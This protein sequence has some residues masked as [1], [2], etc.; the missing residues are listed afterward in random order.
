MRTMY[1]AVTA[2]NIPRSAEMVAGY[3]DKIK[4]EPWTAADWALFPNAVKVTIVKKAS[5]NAGHV[6][7]VEP[8]DATPAQAPGWVRMRRAASADPSIYC[9]KSVWGT[10]Q[11][12]FKDQGVAQ[13]HYWIAWWNGDPTLPSLNGITAVAKQHSGDTAAGVDINSVADFWPGVDG[14]D[15]ATPEEIGKAVWD[16]VVQNKS[17][18]Q[19]IPARELVGWTL[20][21][22][23]R[24]ND[25]LGAVST[26]L[27][28]LA[29]K[30]AAQQGVPT[31]ELAD[32]LLTGLLPEVKA[33][34]ADVQ[35]LD[36][37]AVAAKVDALIAARYAS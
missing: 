31:A 16:S 37:D 33:E 5:T 32:A 27:A 19:N 22:V 21:G 3:I 24:A 14:D 34:L 35:H 26:K 28:D 36:E 10:V 29:L 6:L 23:D 7:D 13:P 4:L 9:N 2:R 17:N 18:G 1:D 12:A 20:R 11:Q 25:T 30:V 8:G 15:M